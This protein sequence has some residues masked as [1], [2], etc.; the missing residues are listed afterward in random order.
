MSGSGDTSLDCIVW[1]QEWG[2]LVDLVERGGSGLGP[3][4]PS[5]IS[6]D[7]ES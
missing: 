6:L 5:A 2:V 1:G 7:S 3:H 4:G